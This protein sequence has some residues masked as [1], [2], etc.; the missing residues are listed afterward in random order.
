MHPLLAIALAL[1]VSLLPLVCTG[2]LYSHPCSDCV[3]GVACDHEEGCTDDPCG[4][5]V[6]RSEAQRDGPVTDLALTGGLPLPAVHPGWPC[7][8]LLRG[9]PSSWDSP[10]SRVSFGRSLPLLI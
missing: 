7:T 2:G 3:D 8:D 4:T 5:Q 10:S 9:R 1:W 6:L